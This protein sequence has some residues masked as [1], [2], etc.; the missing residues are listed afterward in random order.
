MLCNSVELTW[1]PYLDLKDCDRG[2]RNC[3]TT[4][5]MAEALQFVAKLTNFKV[6]VFLISSLLMQNSGFILCQQVEFVTRLDGDWGTVP[7]DGTPANISGTW[8]GVVG[9]V[10]NGYHHMAVAGWI[11]NY[12]RRQPFFFS[13]VTQ[14]L[15]YHL[16]TDIDR[17]NE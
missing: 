7:K 9:D 12:E 1:D 10:L 17:S 16:H 3:T 15:I 14:K 4:G 5:I 6:N 2:G 8:G 11:N 13:F